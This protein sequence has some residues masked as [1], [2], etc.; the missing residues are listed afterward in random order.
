MNSAC[1][2]LLGNDVHEISDAVDTSCI[3]LYNT[4]PTRLHTSLNPAMH[5]Q[6]PHSTDPQ[7]LMAT[8]VLLY[9]IPLH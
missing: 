4:A 7:G 9:I 2:H 3:V 8:Q 6:W 1:R 5:V